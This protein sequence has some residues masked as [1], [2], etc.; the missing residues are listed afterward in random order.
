MRKGRSQAGLHEG[1]LASV[2][3]RS[4]RVFQH[5]LQQLSPFTLLLNLLER[6]VKCGQTL[7]SRRMGDV[8]LRALSPDRRRSILRQNCLI[9]RTS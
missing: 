9:T 3:R 8:H 6:H 4:L 2:N 7:G 1:Q 5:R